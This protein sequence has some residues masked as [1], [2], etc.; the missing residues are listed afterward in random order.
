[1]SGRGVGRRLKQLHDGPT[2]AISIRYRSVFKF[3]SLLM[4]STT[5]IS[6]STLF[7]NILSLLNVRVMRDVRLSNSNVF[8][9]TMK[10]RV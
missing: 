6:L 10:C 2:K 8:S 7:S 1:M 5:S 4:L 3:I 9:V